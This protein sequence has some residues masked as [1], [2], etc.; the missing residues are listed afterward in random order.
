ML[1]NIVST[2]K[3]HEEYGGV[4]PELAGRA[5]QQHILPVVDAALKKAGITVNDIDAIA[6]TQGPGLMGSLLV[7]SQFAKGFALALDKPLIGVHHLQAHIAAHYL[8]EEPPEFPFLCL[9][10]SG[11]HTQILKVNT[12]LETEILGSTIDDAAG[13]AF[14]KAAKMIGIPYPGGP[15][16]DRYAEQG[17]PIAYGFPIARLKGYD[18]SFSGLKTSILYFLQKQTAVNPDFIKEN[19]NDICASVRHTIVKTLLDNF[20]R[21]MVDSGIRQIGIAGG[22]SANSLLR[23]EFEK[24]GQKYK[25]KTYIPE[26]QYCTDNAGMIGIA[27]HYRYLAEQFTPLDALPF[28]RD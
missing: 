21:A 28:A 5:H 25:A 20:E 10:V 11:G 1:A 22:V 14:D 19:L 27:G 13:E 3:I 15:L 26:F 24:L 12:H 7:G 8:N 17:N 4:I 9:L 6:Y 2:Q 16:I 23:S 18:Y